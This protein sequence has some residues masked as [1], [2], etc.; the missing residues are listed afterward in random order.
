MQAEDD[1]LLAA[2]PV[3]NQEI[4]LRAAA[5]HFCARVVPIRVLTKPSYYCLYGF[6]RDVSVRG[7]SLRCKHALLPGSQVAIDWNFGDPADQRTLRAR[8]VHTAAAADGG[9]V[10]GCAFETPLTDADVRNLLSP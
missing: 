3:T 6:V 7:M 9:W 4:D 1:E 8:V 5:R 10:I 2:Y